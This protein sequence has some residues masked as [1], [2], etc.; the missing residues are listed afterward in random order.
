MAVESSDMMKNVANESNLWKM[1]NL[2][3]KTGEKELPYIALR[4]DIL[5]KWL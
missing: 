1:H 3:D 5:T 4:M 2:P